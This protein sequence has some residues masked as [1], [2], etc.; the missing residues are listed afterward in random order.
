MLSLTGFDQIT[1]V[2]F[3]W[4]GAIKKIFTRETLRTVPVETDQAHRVHPKY[5][6]KLVVTPREGVYTLFDMTNDAFSRYAGRKCVASREFLGWK[7]PKVK[8]FGEVKWKSYEEVGVLSRKFGA[9]LRKQGLVAAADTATLDEIATPCTVAIF[10]NT[11]SE[12]LIAAIGAFS[13]SLTV[14]TIYATLGLEAVITAINDGSIPAIVCNRMNVEKI[15]DRINEMPT[16]KTII[17]TSDLVVPDDD[18]PLPSPPSGIKIYE[19]FDFCKSGNTKA[20]PPRPP[21]PDSCAV[22]MYTSGSTGKAKGL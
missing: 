2:S 10:E 17:Y 3:G 14:T 22:I 16:L 7:S 5:K 20:F 18:T 13:Q 9:A 4:I 1:L 19:F 11:C 8:H 6:N 12:W 21:T 15:L